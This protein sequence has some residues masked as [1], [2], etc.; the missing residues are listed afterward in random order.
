MMSNSVLDDSGHCIFRTV[1]WLHVVLACSC[2]VAA[3]WWG[4]YTNSIC[5]CLSGVLFCWDDAS[6]EFGVAFSMGNNGG[7]FVEILWHLSIVVKDYACNEV[8]IPR[9]QSP[10]DTN[11]GKQ[12][13]SPYAC[14]RTDERRTDPGNNCQAARDLTPS[15]HCLLGC[16]TTLCAQDISMSANPCQYF[17]LYPSA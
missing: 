3:G 4:D 16:A 6:G 10:S 5:C 13:E 11:G 8:W 2:C 14:F 17:H 15:D 7:S 9:A 12:D 1:F